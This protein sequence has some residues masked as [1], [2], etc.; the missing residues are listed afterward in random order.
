VN[1]PATV[2]RDTRGVVGA[3]EDAVA[4]EDAGAGDAGAPEH[5]VAHSSAITHG[6]VTAA[7]LRR[8]GP[9]AI[10]MA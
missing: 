10:R 9:Q 6:T 5:A 4:A 7:V 8:G 2:V 3:A 1:R